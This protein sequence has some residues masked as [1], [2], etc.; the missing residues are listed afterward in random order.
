MSKKKIQPPKTDQQYAASYD[1]KIARRFLE[2][3]WPYRRRYTLGFAFMLIESA[4][5]VGGPY[6]VSVAIDEGIAVGNVV[7]LRNAVLLYLLLYRV[8]PVLLS[9]KGVFANRELTVLMAISVGIG[10]TLAAHSLGISPALGAFVA[11]ML[12]AESPFAN[13]IQADIG[14]LRIVMVTL[15]FAS[16]GIL[17]SGFD[18]IRREVARLS[19][20][21]LVSDGRIHPARI[22]EVVSKTKKEVDQEILETG[23]RTVIDL[24]I[25]NMHHELIKLIG[26]MK[27]RASYGQNLLAHSIDPGR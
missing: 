21:K 19:L 24:G 22:E 4:A 13:Q 1:P 12:L 7:A 25:H 16:V 3:L 15:F 5:V 14:S 6:L 8:A 20:Q 26:R 10:A 11:G 18:P 9:A 2:F 23:K 17:L 27:Y